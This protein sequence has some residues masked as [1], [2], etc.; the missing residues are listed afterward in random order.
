MP[1]E[2]QS[3]GEQIALLHGPEHVGSALLLALEQRGI[4]L[5]QIEHPDELTGSAAALVLLDPTLLR[6]A[7]LQTWQEQID[8]YNPDCLLLAAAGVAGEGVD[9]QLPADLNAVSSVNLIQLALR[10]WVLERENRQL[11]Q[12]LDKT[13]QD[14]QMLTDIGIALSAEKDL[15]RLLDKIL[16][17]A[18]NLACCDAASLFLVEKR[19]NARPQLTFKLTRNDSI[20]ADF[21]EQ[22]MELDRS[23]IAGY[24]AVTDEELNIP[25]AYEIPPG[26]PYSFNPEIDRALDY[27]TVSLLTMPIRNYRGETIGVLQFINRKTRRTVLLKTPE[28]ALAETLPF[29]EEQIKILRAL[30]SQSAVAIENSVLLEN[31]NQLFSGFVQAAVAAIEQRDPTTS[32]HSFRVADL[33]VEL[34]TKLELAR[35]P[36]YKDVRFGERAIKELRYAA[37]LHDFGKVGVREHILVK[38]KKLPVRQFELIRYR[39]RL[40]QEILRRQL[41]EQLLQASEQKAD[42][43]HTESVKQ[44]AEAELARLEQFLQAVAHANEP[45]LLDG[46]D[47]EH[48]KELREYP[49]NFEDEGLDR[50]ISEDEFARLSVGKGSLTP[51]ERKEIESHVVHT[52]DFLRLIPWTPELARIP[53]IAEAHHEKLDGSGYPFGKSA[54]DIPVGSKIMT[55]CDIFDAL[56]A[57]DRPYKGA[58]D[59]DTA[60]SILQE[61]ASAGKLD[62]ALV[63]LFIDAKVC[64]IV[65]GKE[66]ADLSGGGASNH[67][68]D[69]EFHDHQA[70]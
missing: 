32:G 65:E 56:T 27:R 61:E 46:G 20:D 37:L 21:Q 5:R 13:E 43:A 6:V 17:E 51:A 25:N 39:I 36:H 49:F 4:A 42:A 14:L 10:R 15:N 48:L 7:P 69:P 47:F 1:P 70:H 9:L 60:Y 22:Q 24:V 26:E 45:S 50:L 29:H 12:L 58:V 67:P 38:A 40:A 28:I 18:Q 55:I 16:S 33:T 2:G 31:I 68:C 19:E 54:R 59:R 53:E 34:A 62:S 3:T 57:S 44:A 8:E 64:R 11:Q 23:S 35:I 41:S 66:Y 30:A 63:D 52:A